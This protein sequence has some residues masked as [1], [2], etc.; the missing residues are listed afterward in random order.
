MAT[1]KIG[2]IGVSVPGATATILGEE[3]GKFKRYQ[4]DALPSGDGLNTDEVNALLNNT[5]VPNLVPSGGSVGQILVKTAFGRAWVDLTGGS[6][7]VPTTPPA[8]AP[9]PSS[10]DYDYVL[11][12]AA[13]NASTLNMRTKTAQLA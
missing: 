13:A 12:V 10:T 5:I 8:P 11:S 6:V 1:I 2:D 4:I 3:G 9:P 7:V